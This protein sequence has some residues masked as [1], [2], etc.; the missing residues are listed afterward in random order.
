MRTHF[1][2]HAGQNDA[3][4]SRCFH[5]GVRQPGMERNIGT[6]TAKAARRPGT[7]TFGMQYVDPQLEFKNVEGAH[8]EV[9]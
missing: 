1:Q 2:Q 9:E 5:V 3:A 4:R 8:L 7:A 6:L